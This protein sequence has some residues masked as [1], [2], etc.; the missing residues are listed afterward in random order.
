MTIVCID[1]PN[2]TKARRFTASDVGRIACHAIDA[3]VV[4]EEI[5]FQ[6]NR[7]CPSMVVCDCK[8][9]STV[10]IAVLKVLAAVLTFLIAVGVVLN[11][12]LV[13]IRRIPGLRRIPIIRRFILL[14]E[15]LP[16][17]TLEI[18]LL[19]SEVTAVLKKLPPAP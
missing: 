14:L 13:A 10:L 18:R 8:E 19:Q 1:R 5:I 15:S 7:R 3:G 17:L 16:A 11:L 6:L 2:R 12:M 4:R 9:I